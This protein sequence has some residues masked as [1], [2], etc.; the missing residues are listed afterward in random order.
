MM[1]NLTRRKMVLVSRDSL[2]ALSEGLLKYNPDFRV[3]FGRY[4][5]RKP[6]LLVKKIGCE[7]EG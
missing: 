1:A 4:I 2:V 3:R 6:K 7:G 5:I